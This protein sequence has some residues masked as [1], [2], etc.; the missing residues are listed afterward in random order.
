M[1]EGLVLESMEQTISLVW[2]RLTHRYINP[3]WREAPREHRMLTQY[4]F[5][6]ELIDD[7][8]VWWLHP[9]HSKTR[10]QDS[11]YGKSLTEVVELYARGLAQAIGYDWAF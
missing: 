9:N 3:N 5:D 7:E 6:T 10:T 4:T 8:N 2:N 11:V 1:E